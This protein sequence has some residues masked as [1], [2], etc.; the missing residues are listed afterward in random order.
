MTLLRAGCGY[1]MRTFRAGTMEIAGQC[2][3][4]RLQTAALPIQAR[5]V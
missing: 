4:F 3:G 1:R 2:G 5:I